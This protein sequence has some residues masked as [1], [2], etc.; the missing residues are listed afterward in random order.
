MAKIR[1]RHVNL[2]KNP[3][4]DPEDLD[5]F[6]DEIR[7][8]VARAFWVTQWA[9]A[10]EEVG[11]TYPGEDLM[12]VAPRT[13]E[14][15]L[16][17]ADKFLAEL[18]ENNGKTVEALLAAA[19]EADELDEDDLDG[20]YAEEFGHYMAMQAMGHGVGWFDDHEHFE[21]TVPYYEPTDLLD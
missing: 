14:E 10:E 18:A 7:E 5:V 9:D 15:A 20:D 6:R 3:A 21:V 12:D 8:A 19:A 4:H 17:E 11:N 13:P 16:R 2:R 1:G